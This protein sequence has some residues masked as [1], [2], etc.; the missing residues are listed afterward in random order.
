MVLLSLLKKGTAKEKV[1]CSSFQQF[2]LSFS[3]FVV[4]LFSFSG[5]FEV[6]DRDNSGYLSRSE[7]EFIFNLIF[8]FYPEACNGRTPKEFVDQLFDALDCNNDDKLSF[9][10]SHSLSLSLF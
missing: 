10:F 4:T 1:K 5:L 7:L 6:L 3:L 8:T 9:R 2:R